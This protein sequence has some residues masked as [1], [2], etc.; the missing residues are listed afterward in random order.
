MIGVLHPNYVGERIT[1]DDR[2]APAR[3]VVE[4]SGPITPAL[5]GRDRAAEHALLPIAVDQRMTR[6]FAR[7]PMQ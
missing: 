5:N 6:A 3:V 2:R 7:L 4:G 1:K